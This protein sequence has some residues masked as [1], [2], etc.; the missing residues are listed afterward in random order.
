M[1]DC[2]RGE[3]GQVTILLLGVAMALLLGVLVL[4]AIAQD[5]R[6]E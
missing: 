1:S 4:G 6:P 2:V 5:W 3:R